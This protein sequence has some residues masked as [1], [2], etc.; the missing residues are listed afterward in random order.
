MQKI[1]SYIKESRQ[2]LGKVHWPSRKELMAHTGLV[3][4]VSLALATF[5]GVLDFLFTKGLELF[6]RLR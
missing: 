5:I 1:G 2:E 4:G 3:I 6:L